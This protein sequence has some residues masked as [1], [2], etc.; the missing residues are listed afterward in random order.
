MVIA[1]HPT[2]NA[3]STAVVEAL[4]EAQLLRMFYTCIVWRRD[5]LLARLTPGGVRRIM[6]RRARVKLSPELV[7]TRPF[8]ELMRNLLPRLRQQRWTA[9]ETAPFSIDAVYRDVDRAV[10]R[11]LKRHQGVRG[12]YAYEGGALQQFQV[13]GPMG[14]HRFYDL[15]IG[16]WRVN[17]EISS[18]EFDLQP[19]WR[20]TLNA[21]ADSEAKV[22]SKDEEIALADSIFVASTFTKRTLEKYPGKVAPVT[23]I[24]YGTPPPTVIDRGPGEKGA[25]LRV[26]YVGSLTQ[27]KGISYLFEA[28]EKLGG[29]ATLTVVGRKVGQSDALDRACARHRWIA[30]LPHREI[31]AEMQQHDVFVFPSLFEGF[32]LVIGEALSQGLPV[33]TTSHTG[34]PDILREGRDGFIVP[35]RDAEAIAARLLQLHDDREL[36]RE[37]SENARA[38]AGELSWQGYRDG[39]VAAVRAALGVA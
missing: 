7:H 15:P 17:R 3:N 27:R 24:P 16:Y 34:G 4:A 1:S 22:A 26:I 28:M 33:I 37:M 29:A 30:S 19:A 20:G 31:L 32:G 10:A 11:G 18:E 36:L 2:G 14:I 38:R 39:T 23:V 8:R 13:A 21:L 9:A 25:P 12:V 35:I 6:E 5:S